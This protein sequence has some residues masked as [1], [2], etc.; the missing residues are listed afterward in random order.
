[1]ALSDGDLLERWRAGDAA[2]GEALFERYYDVVDRFFV[3]K[4]RSAV[5]DLVQETFTRCVA[6][7][8]RLRDNEQFRFYLF[9]I[10][11]NVLKAHFRDRYR[12]GELPE[13]DASSVR[14]LEPGPLTMMVRRREHRLLLEGLRTIPVE[15]QAILELHYWENLTTDEIADV[16]EIPRG[17]ARGRLQRARDK[18]GDAIHH[19]SASSQDLAS[20]LACLDDW[21][22]D[23]RAHLDGYRN[24]T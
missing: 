5:Q 14:D 24:G 9:G 8:E 7:R 22:K 17:T 20:T 1:M 23:C 18:L 6:G 11:L 21:A 4:I 15:D 12:G 10:A 16:L 19:L 3:N 13:L 2:S